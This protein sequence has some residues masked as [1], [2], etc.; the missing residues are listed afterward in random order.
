MTER[1]CVGGRTNGKMG[2]PRP[3]SL[4]LPRY[5]EA[6]SVPQGGKFVSVSFRHYGGL[7]HRVS[8]TEVAS[9]GQLAY[10]GNTSVHDKAYLSQNPQC[11][12]E[13]SPRF[14]VQIPNRRSMMS[15]AWQQAFVVI[16][17]V[18]GHTAVVAGQDR[19][20]VPPHGVFPMAIGLQFTEGP[21]ADAQGNVYFTN[22]PKNQILRWSPN[23]GVTLYRENSGG[24]NG[25]AFDRAG[26]LLACQGGLHR[27]V[28]FDPQGKQTVI[29][30]TYQGKP[31]NEPNDL[32]IDPK[33][34]VYFSDPMYS[35]TSKTQDG[36]HVYYVTPDRK[37][38]LR[39][40]SDLVRPNGLV[41]TRDGKMLYVTDEGGK[42][43][44]VY[45][46]ES[47]GTLSHKRLFAPIGADGIK[48]DNDGNLYL[49][50][51]GVLVYDPTGKRIKKIEV[52]QRPA[53]LCFWGKDG[54][55]LFITARTGVYMTRVKE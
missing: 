42:K 24:A 19:P 35:G 11:P 28:S 12:D 14:N 26:N 18:V 22:I 49:T 46:I 25:L 47:D 2:H 51:D 16:L 52:P 27:V 54:K 15:K 34:G 3:P 31:F 44:F 48:L 38:V 45:Q 10:I 41:G 8:A 1:H 40:T 33:G 5:H 21:A 9:R 39:V 6:N 29:A 37:K 13:L 32:W 53:N 17:L 43:T 7:I 23:G 50:E 4:W 55:T 36:E 20:V 30:D